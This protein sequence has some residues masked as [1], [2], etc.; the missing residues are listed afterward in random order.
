MLLSKTAMVKWNASN[1]K[2]YEGLGYKYTKIGDEFEVNIE[3]LQKSSTSK[4]KC[5]CDY[6][7][8]ELS[9]RYCDYNR[10]V[11]NDYKTYCNICSYMNTYYNSINFK[12]LYDW[13]IENNR[14]DVLNR[15]DY[16]LNGCSPKDICYASSSKKY[17]FKCDKHTEHKS[18]LKN[19][20]SFTSS[21]GSIK[22]N[23]CNSIA[24]YILDNFPNKKLE[25]VWDF[26][27]NS[28]LD[29]WNI[30]RGSKLK[31]YWFI[32]QEKDYHGSYEMICYNFINGHR[33]PYCCNRA[34]KI[35][36]KDSLGQ[37]IIDEYGEEFLW[38]IWSSKNK[39]SPFEYAFKSHIGIWWKCPNNK[40][41]DYKRRVIESTIAEF[42]C[43]IC[44]KER[45]E[46]IIEE[47]TKTYLE[48]LGYEVLTEYKCT[49]IPINPKTKH[50]M[51]FD[52]EIV[53]P[54]EKHLIIEVH[55]EQ[56]Y[57]NNFY[58]VINKCTEE[59]AN[60]IL[61]QRQLY[62]RYKR[63]YAKHMGYEYI[64]IPY[65]VFDKKET[66]KQMIDNKIKEILKE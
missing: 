11:K 54:N 45:S 10:S 46:S 22:C 61:H 38:A 55:G 33:C 16:E 21:K 60:K 30:S 36:P 29:P 56:H 37:Y 51:P 59:E 39:K 62:D 52:N 18:E 6:C 17:W 4:V 66:Y 47:K 58:K 63:I 26:E 9:W 23:Q 65:T 8:K 64:E 27:K 19:I 49:I 31:K 15:W 3:D 43:P 35:H 24:Q 41:E 44:S 1:K 12:S 48:E 53:F 28:G 42:R 34:G 57:N 5:L 14:Q 7:G 40:H 2:H 20:G 13:C 32:C 25:E 50:S